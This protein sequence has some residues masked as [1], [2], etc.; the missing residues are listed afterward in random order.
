[1]L[2]FFFLLLLMLLLSS[3]LSSLLPYLLPLPSVLM[4]A[5]FDSKVMVCGNNGIDD[6][7]PYQSCVW[8]WG[9]AGGVCVSLCAG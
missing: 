9:R 1:L 3:L 5:F 2:P 6:D 4:S 7:I 8:G